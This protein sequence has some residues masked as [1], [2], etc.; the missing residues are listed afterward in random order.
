MFTGN[1]GAAEKTSRVLF[2]L[3]DSP[4]AIAKSCIFHLKRCKG[5][6]PVYE[7]APCCLHYDIIRHYFYCCGCG[8]CFLYHLVVF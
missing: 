4:L 3:N 5:L 7:N 8:F 1:V 6:I 2:P